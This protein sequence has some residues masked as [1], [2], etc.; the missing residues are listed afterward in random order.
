MAL[1]S[2]LNPK[3]SLSKATWEPN[4]LEQFGQ[5]FAYESN[6]QIFA[7]KQLGDPKRQAPEA[8]EPAQT[9]LGE[10]AQLL[11]RAVSDAIPLVTSGLVVRYGLAG[12]FRAPAEVIPLMRRSSL[13]PNLSETVLMGGI[14]G[15]LLTPSEHVERKETAQMARVV[16]D[17]FIGGLSSMV[18][19]STLAYSSY[20]LNKIGVLSSSELVRGALT[21][22]IGNGILS[23]IPGAIAA[24]G[25]ELVAHAPSIEDPPDLAKNVYQSMLIGGLFSTATMGIGRLERKSFDGKLNN[26]FGESTA[27]KVRSLE[28]DSLDSRSL[29]V[30]ARNHN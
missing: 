21:H 4:L 25:I 11:G 23:G 26:L 30:T 6:R 15:G 29:A 14:S 1:D 5:S 12:T 8:P 9:I 3:E 27:D 24:T 13:L 2:D 16:V 17:R 19:F 18:A 7:I 22:P 28:V 20:N 10:H